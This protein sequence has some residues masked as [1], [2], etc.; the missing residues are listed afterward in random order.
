MALA[1]EV[2]IALLV[3]LAIFGIILFWRSRLHTPRGPED[4]RL[5]RAG[6]TQLIWLVLGLV[7]VALAGLNIAVSDATWLGVAQL[8]M[9]IAFIAR[10]IGI[11]AD[12]A[13]VPT[14]R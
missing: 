6:S 3:W 9:G 13:R 14:N 4:A 8:G 2:L 7:F 5:P 11:R 1:L 10:H 12:R